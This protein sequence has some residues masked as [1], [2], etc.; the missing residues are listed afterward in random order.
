MKTFKR[1]KVELCELGIL[2]WDSTQKAKNIAI[3]LNCLHFGLVISF[4]ATLSWFILF[5]AQ[6]NREHTKASFFL[7]SE[8]LL[9]AWYAFCFWHKETIAKLFDDLDAIVEKR[10]LTL[11]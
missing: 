11:L 3:A 4:K 6:T 5:T 1:L 8:V 10:E 7:S 9:L 2:R